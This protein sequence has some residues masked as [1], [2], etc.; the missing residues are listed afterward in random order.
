MCITEAMEEAEEEGADEGRSNE[1]LGVKP[2]RAGGRGRAEGRGA[3]GWQ[4]VR[5]VKKH[6]KLSWLI[7]QLLSYN[8]S[9]AISSHV[10]LE[11]YS[12]IV[13]NVKRMPTN[14]ETIPPVEK[15]RIHRNQFSKVFF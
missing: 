13:Q 11:F 6:L 9:A 15:K 12:L 1:E 14:A 7:S 5:E 2:S 4:K 3:A 10:F 8:N